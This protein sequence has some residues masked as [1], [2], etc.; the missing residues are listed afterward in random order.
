MTPTVVRKEYDI[1]FSLMDVQDMN[2]EIKSVK[3]DTCRSNTPSAHSRQSG[4]IGSS[5]LVFVTV[6]EVSS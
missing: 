2:L 6:A 5:D 4:H 3:N 1:L